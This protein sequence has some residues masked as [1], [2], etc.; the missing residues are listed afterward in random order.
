M[1]FFWLECIARKW[2]DV[3]LA[4]SHSEAKRAA[5]EIGYAQDKLQVIM[6]SIN[7][8][9][10]IT[11]RD[12][13]GNMK[14]GMIGRL[15]PQKNP[16]LF[17]L[18]AEKLLS[19]YPQ[20]QFTILGAG[21]N[22]SLGNELQEFITSRNFQNNI[23]LLPWG[24]A[25]TSRQFIAHTDVFVMT[26]VFEG[27][28]FSLLEAMAAGCPCVVAV[29]D[30]NSDVIQN[31]ENGFSC[32]SVEEFSQ[33]IE[34]LINNK[35]LREKIGKAAAAYV[36]EKHNIDIAINELQDLYKKF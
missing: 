26:S 36:H 14:I 17:L 10:D 22:D 11:P 19:K 4:V 28:P 3:L 35:G 34:L 21:L 7:A 18:I 12:Y 1:F 25:G 29:A 9:T 30:G 20:L 8:T 13:S 27:L 15:T 6:N 32:L 31:N 24:D 33:K 5:F 16:M 23:S 2:S